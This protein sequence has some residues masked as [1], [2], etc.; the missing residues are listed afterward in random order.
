MYLLNTEETW[1]WLW[2][3]VNKRC[4]TVNYWR[5][6]TLR[7]PGSVVGIAT[8]YGLDGPGIESRWEARFSAPVQT[9]R[10]ADPASCT[11]G[12]G[13]FP[14][15]KSGRGATLTP[16]LL[17]AP[18]SRKS[19]AIPLLPLWA[20]RPVHSLS[21]CTRVNFTFYL[22]LYILHFIAL[23]YF[24]FIYCYFHRGCN[25]DLFVS[26]TNIWTLTNYNGFYP[27]IMFCILLVRH[28]G[29][30]QLSRYS[31]WLRAGRSVDRIPVG[32]EIFL[33]RPDRPWGLP[34]LLYNGY[35][36]FP[37]GKA[38][39]SWRWPLT[40]SIAEVRGRVELHPGTSWPVLGWNLRTRH[41]KV[42]QR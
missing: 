13:S 9:G 22:T 12:T 38:V 3:L 21:A 42:P 2:I 11:M 34:S 32:G 20:V 4:W 28:S 33:T 30:G 17:L 5:L 25:Y 1:S 35:R 40:P 8:G 26:P 6:H 10:G 24:N 16:H 19:R 14:G 39:G 41:N 27:T 23:H 18:W 7:R 37:G 36:V 31:Y 29:P 15:V